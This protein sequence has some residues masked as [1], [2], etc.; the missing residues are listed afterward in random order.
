MSRDIAI[1]GRRKTNIADAPGRRYFDGSQ[2]D[3]LFKRDRAFLSLKYENLSEGKNRRD[4]SLTSSV[5][6]KRIL[7]QLRFAI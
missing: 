7:S 3:S 2:R 1:S 6:P 5:G 4:T